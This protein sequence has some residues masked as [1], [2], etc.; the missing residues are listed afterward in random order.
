[1]I[2]ENHQ[3]RW[4]RVQLAQLRKLVNAGASPLRTARTLNRSLIA[5]KVRAR[6]LGLLFKHRR[7]PLTLR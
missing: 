7:F 4:T 2:P 3:K 1:M 6:K 5:I